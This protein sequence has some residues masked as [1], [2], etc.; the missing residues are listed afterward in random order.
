MKRAYTAPVDSER[1]EAHADTAAGNEGGR[2][3][4]RRKYGALCQQHAARAYP[5]LVEVLRAEL[6][7]RDAAAEDTQHS[8]RRVYE[9]E[10]G[11]SIRALLRELGE[12]VS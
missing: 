4:H 11:A 7:E 2:C 9:Q 12:D 6:T 8:V 1:C 3:M 5:K 10:R